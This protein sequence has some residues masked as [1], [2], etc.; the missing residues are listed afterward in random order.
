MF[1]LPSVTFVETPTTSPPVT[2]QYCTAERTS[3]ST[4][5][6]E[7]GQNLSEN[8]E[9]PRG[10]RYSEYSPRKYV[11][12]GHECRGVLRFPGRVECFPLGGGNVGNGDGH[13]KYVM[14]SLAIVLE[15]MLHMLTS[16]T[17]RQKCNYGASCRLVVYRFNINNARIAL[18]IYRFGIVRLGGSA[19]NVFGVFCPVFPSSWASLSLCL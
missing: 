10:S 1:P 4:L 13:Q 19:R 11:R 17:V 12:G 16:T 9:A 15:S 3:L 18:I 5:S 7:K 8:K 2:C 14:S 6:R